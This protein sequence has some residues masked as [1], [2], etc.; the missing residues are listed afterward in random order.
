MNTYRISKNFILQSATSALVVLVSLASHAVT[1]KK[2]S[3]KLPNQLY[4][5]FAFV[6]KE[7]M[8]LL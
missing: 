3:Y 4:I 5:N 7:Y 1:A 6:L 8:N 2:F